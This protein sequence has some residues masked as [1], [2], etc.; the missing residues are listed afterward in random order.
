MPAFGPRRPADAAHGTGN[1]R[2][3]ICP[4]RCR[5]SATGRP[6]TRRS[7]RLA[8]QDGGN[9]RHETS[10]PCREGLQS[11][12]RHSRTLMKLTVIFKCPAKKLFA[13]VAGTVLAAATALPAGSALPGGFLR[14]AAAATTR[15]VTAAAA[16]T[17]DKKAVDRI[18]R[19]RKYD[20]AHNKGFAHDTPS[21]IP[22][23]RRNTTARQGCAIYSASAAG[24][25]RQAGTGA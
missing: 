19:R 9:T 12:Q 16:G 23:G 15:A 7:P 5:G 22:A 11:R 2:P 1:G 13:A 8:R 3:A 14:G 21:F 17:T 25:S 18:G 10:R 24:S 6:R 20:S 4:V